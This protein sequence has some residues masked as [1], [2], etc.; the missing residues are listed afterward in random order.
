M[1]AVKGIKANTGG[2]TRG[3]VRGREGGRTGAS[4]Q[5]HDGDVD[6]SGNA[7]LNLLLHESLDQLRAALP[8]NKVPN[9]Q[10]SHA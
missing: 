5:P 1:K 10:P 7:H 8:G 9:V 2:G 3:P 6:A 4:A